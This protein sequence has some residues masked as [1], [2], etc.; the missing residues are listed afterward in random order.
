MLRI[1]WRIFLFFLLT[2][3]T[4]AAVW[5]VVLLPGKNKRRRAMR[6]RRWWA[7]GL[8][9]AVGTR[10]RCV[11]QPP[12]APC[13]LVGNHRSWIDPILVLRDADAFPVAKAEFASWPIISSG[14]K[15]SG[16]ILV[17]RDNRKS[18]AE[19]LRAVERVVREGYQALIYPEGT[20][21]DV[22]TTLPFQ[23]GVFQLAARNGFAVAPVALIF[24]KSEDYWLDFTPFL[25]HAA[26][27]FR[28]R[29][30]RFELHYGPLMQ[31]EDPQ[32]LREMAEK[33]VGEAIGGSQTL[34]A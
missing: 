4:V 25:V 17:Q 21:S 29:R 31:H 10:V 13:I 33:W 20:T 9:H 22:P 34:K 15:A 24:E 5:V 12:T 19:A 23:P 28:R 3:L 16:I 32:V 14:A 11:G 18:R 27:M 26:R 2:G 30:V 8:L 1:S 7:R 6:V